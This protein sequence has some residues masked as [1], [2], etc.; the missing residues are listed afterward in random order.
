MPLVAIAIAK[1]GG[2]AAL[3]VWVTTKSVTALAGM[4]KVKAKTSLAV[5][6]SLA[7]TVLVT[8]PGAVI[9]DPSVALVRPTVCVPAA[10]AAPVRV[11]VIVI[12]V[13]AT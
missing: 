3:Y 10:V 1:V 5:I 8:V 7:V 12:P 13:P 6:A 11:M 9:P 4:V 2:G